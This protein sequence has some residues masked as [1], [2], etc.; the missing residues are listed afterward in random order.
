MFRSLL[1]EEFGHDEALMRWFDIQV[2]P[3]EHALDKLTTHMGGLRQSPSDSNQRILTAL[4][5]A[6]LDHMCAT[7]KHHRRALGEWL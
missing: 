6:C 7:S 2:E 1:V 5:C 3:H 4:A